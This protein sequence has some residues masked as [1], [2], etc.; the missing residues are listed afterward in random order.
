MIIQC[1]SDQLSYCT[2][3]SKTTKTFVWTARK[4]NKPTTTIPPIPPTLF[5]LN[6]ANDVK[7][8]TIFQSHL[9]VELNIFSTRSI[10]DS[11]TTSGGLTHSWPFMRVLRTVNH[12][13]GYFGNNHTKKKTKLMRLVKGCEFRFLLLFINYSNSNAAL[14]LMDR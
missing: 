6:E 1:L 5:L 3:R 9:F 14:L 13:H 7:P 8:V 2:S 11:F 4:S 10:C 12:T